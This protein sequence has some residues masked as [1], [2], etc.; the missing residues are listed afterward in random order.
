MERWRKLFFPQSVCGC[1]FT[2]SISFKMCLHSVWLT[3]SLIIFYSAL[4]RNKTGTPRCV[5]IWYHAVFFN[6]CIV[7][8]TVLVWMSAHTYSLNTHAH[9]NGS[10]FLCRVIVSA[11]SYSEMMAKEIYF[12]KGLGFV[13]FL[14][15]WD[16]W[17][18]MILA[19]HISYDI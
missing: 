19:L 15:C 17:G 13:F 18:W 14:F 9:K 11:I 8:T 2:D 5:Y 10:V 12:K 16:L 1:F 4:H 6:L 7:K 3:D